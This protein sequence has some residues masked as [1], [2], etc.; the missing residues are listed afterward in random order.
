MSYEFQELAVMQHRKGE[1]SVSPCSDYEMF[2]AGIRLGLSHLGICRQ[3]AEA[4]LILH[5]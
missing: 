2:R 5:T 1:T 4:M 3:G